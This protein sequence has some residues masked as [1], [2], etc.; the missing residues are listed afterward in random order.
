MTVS[1]DLDRNVPIPGGTQAMAETADGGT[2]LFELPREAGFEATP[3]TLTAVRTV[4]PA[5]DRIVS[6]PVSADEPRPLFA[7]PND[8]EHALY[9]GDE[10]LFRLDPGSALT[11]GIEG[12]VDAEA[13]DSEIGRAHV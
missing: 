7:G 4:D 1:A 9:L 13:L 8:Q 12:S 11:V 5:A 3:A 6:H 10:S 2:E